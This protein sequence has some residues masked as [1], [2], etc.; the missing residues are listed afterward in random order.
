[1][2]RVVSCARGPGAG[3]GQNQLPESVYGPPHGGGACA[4]ST[5]VVSLG[6]GGEIVV[7]FV[8]NA[9]ID[10]PGVD[11]LVFGN[12]FV[13]GCR[14]PTNVYAKPAEISVSDDGVTWATYPC[15]ARA[16]PYGSCAGWHPVYSA[17][18]NGI[19]PLDPVRA[20]GDPD[21]LA[22]VGLNHAKYV[23]GRDAQ[24]QA[25]AQGFDVDAIAI[26]NAERP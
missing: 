25:D 10:G 23:R 7:Q 22:D 20:G 3:F 6:A 11:L 14:D 2:N 26:G 16:Y 21:D 9:V 4:G 24:R 19:S 15:T 12:P 13:I 1:M 8:N 5:N 18:D 17:P